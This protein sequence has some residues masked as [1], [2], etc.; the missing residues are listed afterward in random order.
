MVDENTCWA[1][2]QRAR[3]GDILAVQLFDGSEALVEVI[4]AATIMNYPGYSL[5][6]IRV[7]V[8]KPTGPYRKLWYISPTGDRSTPYEYT[9]PIQSDPAYGQDWNTKPLNIFRILCWEDL[10]TLTLIPLYRDLDAKNGA[11]YARYEYEEDQGWFVAARLFLRDAGYSI[12]PALKEREHFQVEAEW[13]RDHFQVWTPTERFGQA[14]RWSCGDIVA[15][16]LRLREKQRE[17]HDTR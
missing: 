17:H 4:G 6:H 14:K 8:L 9:L 13:D 7:T 3:S 5:D 11:E 16:A 10:Q 15:E 1:G 12:L 2:T